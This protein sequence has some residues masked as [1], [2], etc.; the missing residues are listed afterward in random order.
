MFFCAVVQQ[1]TITISS[2]WHSAARGHFAIA[3][4]VVSM[5]MGIYVS[6]GV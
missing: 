4:I 1:L 3:E 6:P 2:A 5:A